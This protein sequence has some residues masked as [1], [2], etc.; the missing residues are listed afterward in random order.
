[1]YRDILGDCFLLR[2]PA[3]SKTVHML[4]DCGILQ[5][6]PGA[7]ERARRIMANVQSV[8]SRLDVLVVTHEHMDHLSGFAQTR[9]FFDTI[10]LDE[11][12]LA[13]TEDPRDDQAN[14]L[15]AGRAQAM[16]LLERSY[17][18]LTGLMSSGDRPD[19]DAE[20]DK[21]SGRPSA[22]DGLRGLMAFSGRGS[23][24]ARRARRNFY[25]GHSGFSTHQSDAR[26]VLQSRRRCFPA[27]RPAGRFDVCVGAAARGDA[28]QA[29]PPTKE[30]TRSL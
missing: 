12:W 4:I 23:G 20:D 17:T 24:P 8:T 6:M 7:K 2:F 5:G 19:D 18:A 26:A 28:T 16:S 22:L 27:R 9:E 10:E 25:S 11:L 1:M 14:R 13:W 30:K 3:K 21:P 15:R 29:Q